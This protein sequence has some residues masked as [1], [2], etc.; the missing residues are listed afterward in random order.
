MLAQLFANKTLCLTTPEVDLSFDY[1]S[2]GQQG[3]AACLGVN[4]KALAG[5]IFTLIG[6]LGGGEAES[7]ARELIG[8]GLADAM[9]F[10]HFDQGS[11]SNGSKYIFS[12]FHSLF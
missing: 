9:A 7:Q 11:I 2:H 10:I 6:L 4:P 8:D 3:Y 5:D 1:D 12:V